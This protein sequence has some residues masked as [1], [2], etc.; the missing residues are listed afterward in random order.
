MD[1]LQQFVQFYRIHRF[2]NKRGTARN[3]NVLVKVGQNLLLNLASLRSKRFR[4][5]WEQRFGVL[6]ARKMGREPKMKYR[7]RLLRRLELG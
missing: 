4:G 3:Q 6:P 2:W 1:I 7:E 5:V